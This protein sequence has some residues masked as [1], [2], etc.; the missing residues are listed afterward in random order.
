MCQDFHW[1]RFGFLT[2]ALCL[3]AVVWVPDFT[4]AAGGTSTVATKGQPAYASPSWPRGVDALVNDASRTTGWNAWFS[5]WPNDVHQYAFEIKSTDDINRLITRLAAIKANMLQIRLSH[6]KE[7]DGLGW[8]TRIPQGNR[9]P[10]IFSIGDQARIDAWYKQVQKPFGVLEF[11]RPPVAIPPTLTIFVQNKLVNLEELKIPKGIGVS[12]GYVPTV[13]H[14]SNTTSAPQQFDG[15][16]TR[17]VEPKSETIQKT[18]D[19]PSRAAW[20][21]I[22]VFLKSRYGRIRR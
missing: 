22:D 1:T 19:E 20:H 6:R 7:P 2:L 14:K 11:T 8:V 3:Q 12:M 4:L 5:E 10:V 21:S 13:F 18:L 9:I 17:T 16:L 15:S